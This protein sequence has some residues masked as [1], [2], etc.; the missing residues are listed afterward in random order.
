MHA[1]NIFTYRTARSWY[2]FYSGFSVFRRAGA[3]VVPIKVKF[4]REEQ[5]VGP[6]L[7]AKFHLERLRVVDLRPKKTLK[8]LNFTNIIA[9]K[10]RIPSAIF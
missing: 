8:I 1:K 3:K 6:L 5:T 4:G 9:P 2:C 10:G 7:S